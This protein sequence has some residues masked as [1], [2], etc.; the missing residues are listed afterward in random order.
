MS[1]S[2]KRHHKQRVIRNRIREIKLKWHNTAQHNPEWVIKTAKGKDNPFTRCSCYMC[3][4]RIEEKLE[5]RRIRRKAKQ[6]IKND[7]D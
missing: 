3:S 1:L 6:D 4:N 7:E 2:E 5:N